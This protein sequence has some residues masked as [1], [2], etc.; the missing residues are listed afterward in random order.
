MVETESWKENEKKITIR[1]IIYVKKEGQKA[2]ILGYKGET[3]KNIGIKVRTQL[4]K[5]LETKVDLFLFVKVREEWPTDLLSYS[6]Q[7]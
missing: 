1:Q 2:I 3:I 4:E 6:G 7:L 5:E